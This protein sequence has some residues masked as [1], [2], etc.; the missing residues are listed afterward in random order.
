MSYTNSR[1]FID[2][3]ETVQKDHGDHLKLPDNLEF[4]AW[5]LSYDFFAPYMFFCDTWNH[6]WKTVWKVYVSVYEA[7]KMLRICLKY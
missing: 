5:V 2:T 6:A 4:P 7:Y 3:D 1:F